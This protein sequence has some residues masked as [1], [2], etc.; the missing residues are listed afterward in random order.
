MIDANP[1]KHYCRLFFWIYRP[2]SMLTNF[3]QVCLFDDHGVDSMKTVSMTQW[4]SSPRI[5][6]VHGASDCDNEESYLSYVAVPKL[7][8]RDCSEIRKSESDETCQTDTLCVRCNLTIH[9]KYTRNESDPQLV[10]RVNFNHPDH[11]VTISNGFIHALHIQLERPAPQPQQRL[12][13]KTIS[14]SLSYAYQQLMYSPF[15]QHS[16]STQ[17]QTMDEIELSFGGGASEMTGKQK[18]T[19]ITAN[20]TY[21]NKN[22]IYSGGGGG[23]S[24]LEGTAGTSGPTIDKTDAADATTLVANIIADFAECETKANYTHNNNN[25]NNLSGKSSTP[26]KGRIFSSSAVSQQMRL[27]RDR[28]KHSTSSSSSSNN[29]N[30]SN[31]GG[32]PKVDSYEFCDETEER[33]EKISLFRKKR[34]ADKK[35]EF[36]EDNSENIIP[37]NRIRTR[38]TSHL[39]NLSGN[40]SLAAISAGSPSFF[41]LTPHHAHRGSPNYGFR[42]PCG[43]PIGNR[44]LRSPVGGGGGGYYPAAASLS[45]SS[46]SAAVASGS[47]IFSPKHQYHFK[48]FNSLP[49]YVFSSP[50]RS[51]GDQLQEILPSNHQDV[52]PLMPPPQQPVAVTLGESPSNS[53]TNHVSTDAVPDEKMVF[54]K[55]VVRRFVEETDA[56]SVITNEEGE[57]L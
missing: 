8:C 31:A 45:P 48:R 42:S 1:N 46:S 23:G 29:N 26:E 10:A 15:V 50:K 27:R 22:Y 20:H 57:R 11:L 41:E 47:G 33:C 56:A 43:S 19:T 21:D 7:G 30:N 18:P 52:A 17:D 3:Y 16:S 55:K 49:P 38:S 13:P 12:M 5:L 28:D 25:N 32:G 39:S 51:A 37:F 2:N 9:T 35:Y 36:S 14:S 44:C 24:E 4:V 6:V 54:S 53:A 34:L 40:A